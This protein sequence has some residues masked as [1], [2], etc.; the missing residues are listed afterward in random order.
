MSLKIYQDFWVTADNSVLNSD[1][2][3][4]PTVSVLLKTKL[5][6]VLNQVGESTAKTFNL[7][8]STLSKNF[9]NKRKRIFNSKFI[10]GTGN[11]AF[12]IW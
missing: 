12:C 10:R 9:F 1:L 8:G 3:K 11:L 6:Q 7:K 4:P 2:C 5:M